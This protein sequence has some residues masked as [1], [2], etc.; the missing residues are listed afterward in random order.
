MGLG[1]GWRLG[2]LAGLPSLLATEWSPLAGSSLSGSPNLRRS[3]DVS[4]D[5]RLLGTTKR[6]SG[7]RTSEQMNCLSRE[8]G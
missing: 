8:L 5:A 3:V 1:M 7:T 2:A 4:M 6:Q